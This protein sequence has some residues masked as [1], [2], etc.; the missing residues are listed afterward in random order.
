MYILTESQQI[1][2]YRVRNGMNADSVVESRYSQSYAVG[3][4]SD[5]RLYYL[6]LFD[7]GAVPPL[8]IDEEGVVKEIA[9]H[10]DVNHPAF[11]AFVECGEIMLGATKYQYLVCEYVEG[12]RLSDM[13]AREGDCSVDDA[14]DIIKFVLEGLQRLSRMEHFQAHNDLTADHVIVMRDN[15]HRMGVKMMGLSH[16]SASSNGKPAFSTKDLNSF[17]RAPET[18]MG[19]FD[20]QS[21]LFSAGVLLYQMLFGVVPWYADLEVCKGNAASIRTV[22]RNARAR[23]LSFESPKVIPESVVMALKKALS[24]NFRHRFGWA[25]DFMKMLDSDYKP[26]QESTDR[27]ERH[28]DVSS[29]EKNSDD[30]SDIGVPDTKTSVRIGTIAGNGFEGVAG[31]TDLKD[32]ISRDFIFLLKHPELARAYKVNPPNGLLLYGPPGCGKTFMA[33]KMAEEAGINCS[34][35]NASDV[36]SVYIHG[37]QGKIADLFARAE[38][39][40]PVLLCFDEFDALVPSRSQVTSDSLSGEVNEF[41]SQLNNCADRG[42]YVVAMT[43]RPDR[44]DSAVLRKGRIDKMIYIPLPDLESRKRIFELNLA[45][46]P[47]EEIDLNK[48]AKLTENYVASDITYMVDAAARQAL[49][50]GTKI[51]QKRLEEIIKDTIPSVSKSEL[52]EYEEM[53][54]RYSEKD[55]NKRPSIGFVAY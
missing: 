6:K 2:E 30:Q 43:N 35:V 28:G 15:D 8:M 48:L 44:I 38:K 50:G 10:R 37:S 45:G 27:T 24:L 23:A 22:V 51:V 47:C 18:F 21:D 52:K 17:Y 46:R 7:M 3:A 11:P 4:L 39:E 31:M 32:A 33:Q 40:A 5:G 19:I 20:R 34:M 16:V 12:E 29:K 25:D 9:V 13:L 41:L 42:I 53:R 54:R 14:V 49:F 55:G 1:G 36:G 26:E